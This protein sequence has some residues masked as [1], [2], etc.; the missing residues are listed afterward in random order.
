MFGEFK[1]KVKII[2]AKIH[3]I[4]LHYKYIR[5]CHN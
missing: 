5:S 2:E 3:V 1:E 4:S